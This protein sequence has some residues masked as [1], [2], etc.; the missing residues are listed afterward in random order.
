MHEKVLAANSHFAFVP[1]VRLKTPETFDV[2]L[3]GVATSDSKTPLK[4]LRDVATRRV[5]L[6]TPDSNLQRNR[7]RRFSRED[8]MFDLKMFEPRQ[9][10]QANSRRRVFGAC[11]S[12]RSSDCVLN[13]EDSGRP[14]V[15]HMT[16]VLD[17]ASDSDPGV[18]I[19]AQLPVGHTKHFD[20]GLL[21]QG[22]LARRLKLI[23]STST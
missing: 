10:G 11:E 13:R 2:N 23:T 4:L 1:S 14:T 9:L 18:G 16:Q 7:T 22:G 15:G 6:T 3:D 5:T 12:D 20:S 19:V 17:H 8:I 21:Q